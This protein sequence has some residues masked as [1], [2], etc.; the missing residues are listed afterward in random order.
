MRKDY[1]YWIIPVYK[2]TEWNYEFLVINQ[3]TYNGDDFWGFPKW[4]AEEWEDWLTAAKR[5][6]AEEVGITDINIKED[7]FYWFDYQFKE[8]WNQY[9]KTVKFR[10]GF[11]ENKEVKIQDEEL[12]WCEWVKYEDAL[13]L[14]THDNMKI[15][16]KKINIILCS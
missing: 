8:R 3:K 13:N 6:L 12:I 1:S 7:K 15:V 10:V 4:H 16:L 11:V 9:D 5:E 2:N 14:I